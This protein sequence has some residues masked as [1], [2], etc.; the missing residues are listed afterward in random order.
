[1]TTPLSRE[2]PPAGLLAACATSARIPPTRAGL[3]APAFSARS[4]AGLYGRE[5][6]TIALGRSARRRARA[7]WP[8]SRPAC[9]PVGEAVLGGMHR[10]GRRVQRRKRIGRAATRLSAIALHGRAMARQTVRMS[11]KD[12]TVVGPP[13]LFCRRERRNFRLSLVAH[14]ERARPRHGA[15]NLAYPQVV[16]VAGLGQV[17]ISVGEVQVECSAGGHKLR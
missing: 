1:M 15:V 8:R 10:E 6:T 13:G 5:T 16:V 3:V 17:A 14:P 2:I 4:R 7:G 12:G 9:Q 11:S